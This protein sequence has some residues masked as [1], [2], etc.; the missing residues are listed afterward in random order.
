MKINIP[1]LLNNTPG[2][3]IKKLVV[4]FFVFSFIVPAKSQPGQKSFKQLFTEGN[5]MMGEHFIDSALQTFIVLYP[6]DTNDANVSYFIGQLYLLTASHRYQALPYL[7]KAAKHVDEKYKPDDPYEK[8]APPQAYYYLARAQH[9]NYK[10]DDAIT[11]FVKFSK[12]LKENDGRHKDIEYWINCCNNAKALMEEPVGC[13]VVNLGDSI[14]S[15]YPDYAPMATADESEILFTSRRPVDKYDSTK[16]INGHYFEDIWMST[17]KL[18]GNGWSM[19]E[20]L[21]PPLD[22]PGNEATV[23]LSA[24]GQEL[25]IYRSGDA[26]GGLYASHLSGFQW[27][28]PNALD[29]SNFG[30]LNGTI[31]QPSACVSPD[32]KTIIFSSNKPGGLGGLDLY[33][34]TI[35]N[36]GKWSTPSNLGP[37]INT[38][39][40][41]DAP[42]IHADDSTMFFSSKGHNT[43]GGYDVFSARENGAGDWGHVKNMGYPIN[44]PDDDMYFNVSPDGKR[45]YYTT[46]RPG[47]YGEMDNYEVIF[48]KPL[49]VQPV[50][51]VVG[52]VKTPDGSQMANDIKVNFATANGNTTSGRVNN[53][54]GKFLAVLR[55]DQSYNTTITTQDKTVFNHNFILTSDSSYPTLSRASYRKIIVLGDTAN[56]FAP[57]AKKVEVASVKTSNVPRGNMSGRLLLN[58]DPL[59]PLSKMPVQLLDQNDNVI[60]TTSTTSD[61]YFTFNNLRADSTYALAAVLKNGKLKHLKQLLLV[62][63]NSQNVR[64][65]DEEK[66][67]SYFY[68]TLPVDL[69]TLTAL[70]SKTSIKTVET[71]TTTTSTANTN[72]ASTSTKVTVLES[73]K[74]DF[75][76]Y[77][78]YNLNDVSEDDAGFTQLID[79]ISTK[80][81]TGKVT[82]TIDA[83]ASTVPTKMFSSSNKRLAADRAKIAKKV[84]LEALSKKNIDGS[85]VSVGITSGVNGPKYRHDAKDESKY[86]HYQY[87]KVYI[88]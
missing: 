4:L 76:R 51:V 27:T 7:E 60:Q 19:A 48:N 33:K 31:Y 63:T 6:K 22:G 66:K 57:P 71:T 68:H 9:L 72:N 5:L 64:N 18:D 11:N 25:I 1:A 28:L 23:S 20:D 78:G 26:G 2:K 54:T 61:G 38:E 70:A 65:Y 45:A 55:P 74:A 35:D 36:S 43:M 44:T 81:A 40:D 41:E 12:L 46:I 58:D 49:Q 8:D 62:N 67:K 56:V 87:V 30:V 69:N 10:F 77:F 88:R 73:D 24:D 75:T 14:N 79:K 34:I 52:Y 42:F 80:T 84:I 59:E 21:G 29:S 39:Y 3:V 82:V 13:K 83:S 16:D 17:A 47:G 15:K 32:K 86:Q 85:K 37:S 53:K 50:A